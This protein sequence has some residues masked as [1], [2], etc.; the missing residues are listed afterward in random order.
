MAVVVRDRGQIFEA[1]GGASNGSAFVGGAASYFGG[2]H[3]LGSVVWLGFG[4][5]VCVGSALLLLLVETF[6]RAVVF[7]ERLDL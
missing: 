4:L 5:L 1:L 3:R 7:D 2:F 6:P